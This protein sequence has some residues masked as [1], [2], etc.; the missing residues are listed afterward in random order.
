MLILLMGFQ[1]HW[2]GAKS[3]V[4]THSES[5][6]KGQNQINTWTLHMILI[7]PA[8][9]RKEMPVLTIRFMRSLLIHIFQ[10]IQN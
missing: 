4:N 8:E 9:M 10:K 5:C 1:T 6:F 2:D 3:T 7:N